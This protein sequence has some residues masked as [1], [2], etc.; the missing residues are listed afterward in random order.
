MVNKRYAIVSLQAFTFFLIFTLTNQPVQAQFSLAELPD[1]ENPKIIGINKEPARATFVPYPDIETA[2]ADDG[3]AY[4]ISQ[5]AANGDSS[6]RRI[7]GA[8]RKI[9]IKPDL[10]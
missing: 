4:N 5:I 6:G 2:L 9:F 8:D 7:R 3:I 10:M 1:W